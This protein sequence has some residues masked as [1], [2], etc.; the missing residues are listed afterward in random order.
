M[1][2]ITPQGEANID[3]DLI[4][5]RENGQETPKAGSVLA[6]MVSASDFFPQDD[7][8]HIGRSTPIQLNVVTPD[9]LL[10]I[11]ERRELAMRARLEQII[12]ELGQLRDLLVAMNRTP[13]P[14]TDPGE[15]K[16][17]SDAEDPKARRLRLLVLRAQQASA[18]VDKSGGELTGVRSEI[19][20]ILAELI[21]N[22]I[23]S[24]DRRERL[25]LKIQIP[26]VA[27][28]GSPWE[29][30]S[31]GVAELEK[32]VSR[33]SPSDREQKIN[34][35][36]TQNAEIIAALTAILNDMIDIQD[37]NEVIDMVRD[38]LEDQS[39]VLEQTKAEQKRRLLEALK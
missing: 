32:V 31:K 8:P 12:S 14:S 5:M 29:S 36:L 6:L 15:R 16:E 2:A 9:Q 20:Q 17:S 4:A 28:L 34:V 26:L 11:L 27:L 35:L 18:Q 23:D 7:T 10:I 22:R 38:M 30:F 3:L 25:E 21:N 33:E 37:F 24:K 13:D 19:A 39:E 1:L